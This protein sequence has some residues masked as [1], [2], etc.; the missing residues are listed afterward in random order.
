MLSTGSSLCVGDLFNI[1]LCRGFV[2][3]GERGAWPIHKRCGEYRLWE[4]K[5][6]TESGSCETE[7]LLAL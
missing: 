2:R 6:M 1:P 4:K 3:D 7:Y 5:K